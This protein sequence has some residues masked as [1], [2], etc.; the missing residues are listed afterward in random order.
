VAVAAVGCSL[1]GVACSHLLLVVVAPAE[2]GGTVPRLTAEYD[3]STGFMHQLTVEYNRRL[4]K[5]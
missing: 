2:Y 5:K 1:W 4:A 3:K